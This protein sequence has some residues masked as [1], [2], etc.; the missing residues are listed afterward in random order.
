MP[1]AEFVTT[2]DQRL[3]NHGAAGHSHDRLLN[4]GSGLPVCGGGGLV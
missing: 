2:R 4:A 1:A 3:L